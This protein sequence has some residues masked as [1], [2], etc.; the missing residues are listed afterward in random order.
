LETEHTYSPAVV[1]D[2]QSCTHEF[3]RGVF[4]HPRD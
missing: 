4:N 3:S 2:P 1:V